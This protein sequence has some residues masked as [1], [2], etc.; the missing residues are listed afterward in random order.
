MSKPKNTKMLQIVLDVFKNVL[1]K[2]EMKE[3]STIASLEIDS[4][5]RVEIM[6]ELEV[7]INEGYSTKIDIPDNYADDIV[8]VGDFATKLELLIKSKTGTEDVETV[9][10]DS[11]AEA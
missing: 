2:Q 5:S 8:T 6:M 3:D 1:N 11:Q 4:L 7:A 9:G 10:S